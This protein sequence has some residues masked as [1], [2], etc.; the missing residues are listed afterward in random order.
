MQ[1][2]LKTVLSVY[3]EVQ[4]KLNVMTTPDVYITQKSTPSEVRNWL[5]AK[6]FSQR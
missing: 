1:E 6:H 5:K 2:E 3:N 4:P